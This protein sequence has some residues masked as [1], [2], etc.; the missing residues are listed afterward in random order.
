MHHC[1]VHSMA[2][3]QM[4]LCILLLSRKM[5]A[6]KFY[7]NALFAINCLFQIVCLVWVSGCVCVHDIGVCL[8]GPKLMCFP[9][10]Q[11]SASLIHLNDNVEPIL[12]MSSAEYDFEQFKTDLRPAI[13]FIFMWFSFYVRKLRFKFI[14]ADHRCEREHSTDCEYSFQV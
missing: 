7:I 4:Y 3:I 5:S 12:I 10:A 6:Y 14:C 11:H 9:C 2:H 8:L 13:T 1:D